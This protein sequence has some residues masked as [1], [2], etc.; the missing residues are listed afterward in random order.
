MSLLKDRGAAILLVFLLTAFP[1]EAAEIALSA[2]MLNRTLERQAFSTGGKRLLSGAIGTCDYAY[3]EYPATSIDGGWVRL[4]AHLSAKKGIKSPFSSD[5]IGPGEAFYITIL[6]RPR[7]NG[8]VLT[9]VDIRVEE[10]KEPYRTI[11][12]G[13]A[14][15]MMQAILRLNLRNEVMR[16]LGGGDG[17]ILT[18]PLLEFQ[19]VEAKNGFVR[20]Q[21]DFVLEAQ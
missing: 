3:L 8:D 9:L 16:M 21:F 5:C 18:V 10:A 15:G 1:I 7:L 14:P 17:T 2:A 12:Q 11:L 19:S 4:R 13:I 6:G 20:L